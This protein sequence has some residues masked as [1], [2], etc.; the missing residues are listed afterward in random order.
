MIIFKNLPSNRV[1]QSSKLSRLLVASMDIEVHLY[2]TVHRSNVHK[3]ET[4]S[5][6][7][8]FVTRRAS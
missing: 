7:R 8:D 1:Y 5:C 4:D 2:I 6:T 3:R